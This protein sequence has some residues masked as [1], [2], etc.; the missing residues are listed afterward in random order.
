MLSQLNV[1]KDKHR[2]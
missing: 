2:S 1:K